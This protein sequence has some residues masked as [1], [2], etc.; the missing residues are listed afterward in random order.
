MTFSDGFESGNTSAWAAT[1]TSAGNFLAVESSD[2]HSGKYALGMVKGVGKRDV[3]IQANLASPGLP[4]SQTS[5]AMKL[6]NPQGHGMLQF[7]QISSG[8][9]FLVGLYLTYNTST[10]YAN[11]QVYDGNYQW[12]TCTL[13][14]TPK[15]FYGAW[16][17]YSLSYVASTSATGSFSLTIDGTVACSASTIKTARSGHPALTSVQFG[18]IG[19]DSSTGMTIRLDDVRITRLAP[20]V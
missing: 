10:G 1:H 20:A 6:A 3:Y 15:T 9:Y 14:S 16:H 2:V 13:P 12:H 8:Q 7:A 18:S 11:L 19:S 17:T 5:W 4:S